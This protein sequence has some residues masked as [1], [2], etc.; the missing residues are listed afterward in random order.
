MVKSVS[1]AIKGRGEKRGL[2]KKH[3]DEDFAQTV[4]DDT[5][6]DR[7]ATDSRVEGKPDAGRH[8][9]GRE[10]EDPTIH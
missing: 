9:S 5:E 10:D 6:E 3:V 7:A 2:T 4:E 8:E 1:W